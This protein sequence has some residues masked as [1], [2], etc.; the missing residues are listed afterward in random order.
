MR[1][2]IYCWALLTALFWFASCEKG[3]KF[4]VEGTIENA[5][6]SMLYF[7]SMGLQKVEVIDKVKLSADGSFSFSGPRPASPEF[8][9][10]RIAGQIINISVDSTET[11]VVNATMPAMSRQYE[12]EGSEECSLIRDIAL[13]QMALQGSIMAVEGDPS[14]SLKA[15][16]DSAVALVN[17]YKDFLKNN[18]IFSNPRSA[19]AYFAL[20]QTIGQYLI[21][22]PNGG[23]EDVK[24][25]AAV[26]TSWQTFYPET[27][28]S[29]HLYNVAFQGL[30]NERI[31]A[32]ANNGI[33]ES[34]ITTAGIIDLHLCDNKG[35][36]RSLSELEGKV[37]L[38]DF[39][40][41]SLED[42][43]ARILKIRE[44]YNKFA[45]RG[46]E[47]YQVSLDSDEH[48]WKQQTSSLPWISVRDDGSSG[49]S[50]LS[51]YNVQQL[52]EF[53][54]I[55]KTNTLVGRSSQIDDIEK[56]IE[57]LL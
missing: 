11:I 35:I 53:F 28:R 24:V 36:E 40:L 41:F 7:E 26:A 13:S 14:L 27:E 55:D 49:S 21:F 20:F 34:Q 3:E 46:F 2:F 51:M 1:H 38:L 32:N 10:L 56:A 33:S 57:Q 44:L 17:E 37:V 31:I 18:Y 22:N 30:K 5:E 43:P 45:S 8:Y 12:V 52:P 23:K 50:S 6:D 47:V 48:F 54:L 25:Y 39:H 4:R 9:R 15:K 16:G 19:S 42:S 29:Q